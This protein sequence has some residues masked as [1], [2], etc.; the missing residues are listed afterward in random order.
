MELPAKEFELH[1]VNHY[2][3]PRVISFDIELLKKKFT[4][5]LR[6]F[7]ISFQP[8]LARWHNKLGIVER[9][10]AVI[11]GIVTKLLHDAEY[12]SEERGIDVLHTEVLSRAKYISNMLYGS[13]V[14][15]NFE[16]VRGYTP[17]MQEL[18]QQ[19]IT[20]ELLPAHEELVAKRALR[21]VE[22]SKVL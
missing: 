4:D 1:W 10:N 7:S 14:V 20:E 16:M 9:K 17:R 2:G 3:P 21:M 6:Y 19:M 12:Y 22:K 13:R 18:P 5:A 11:C 8:C 15:S